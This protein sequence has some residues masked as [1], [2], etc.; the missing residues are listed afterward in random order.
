MSKPFKKTQFSLVDIQ[1]K[2]RKKKGEWRETETERMRDWDIV[3]QD[4]YS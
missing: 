4:T 1:K 2:K 3:V